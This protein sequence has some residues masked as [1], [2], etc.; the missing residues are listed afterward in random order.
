MAQ[1]FFMWGVVYGVVSTATEPFQ[2]EL[3]NKVNSDNPVVPLSPAE[4][5]D[6]V[7]RGYK[8]LAD[9]IT[10]A[11]KSGIK[12]EDL[13]SMIAARETIPPVGD[14]ISLWKRGILADDRLN[15]ALTKLGVD[16]AWLSTFREL[17][18]QPP[19]PFDILD[20]Y[21]EGQV[22]HD[23]A[24]TLY[25]KFGGDPNYFDLLYNT[26]GSAPTPTEA[27]NM[28]NRGIIPWSGHGPDSVAFEQ[29]FLE[30]PW[31]NKWLEPFRKAAE[32]FPPPRTITA[33][34]HEQALTKD[35]A[36]SYLE[37]QGLSPELAASYLIA[38]S[39]R[40]TQK[41]KDLAES[42]IVKLYIDKAVSRD[43]AS[44]MLQ[45]I[46]YTADEADFIL[47]IAD[48]QRIQHFTEV[49][50]NAVHT[51]Y[52]GHKIDAAKASTT[53]DNIGIA[54]DQRDTLVALWNLERG[55]KVAIITAAE[56]RKAVHK[57]LITEEEGLTR[58]A[59]LG[60]SPEDAKLYLQLA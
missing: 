2:Q 11:A 53:L 27:A 32:Y 31:R 36:L 58:L 54:A 17:A 21:L 23:E 4:V 45:Q 15:Q 44:S 51:Q 52:V 16:D 8:T 42:T 60:Y 19:T 10:E 38:G 24:V 43:D 7:R 35:Q 47:L 59:N 13:A 39:N 55:A 28:A 18:V 1:Q 40:K 22:E 30:G 50:I 26:R 5:A 57:S 46:R 6:M 56:V 49:A 14:L 48:L 3:R 29:A 20:A 34:Y 12:R 33:M 41:T 25:K 37:K 9:G